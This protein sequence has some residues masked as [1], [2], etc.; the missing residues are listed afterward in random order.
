MRALVPAVFLS[1]AACAQRATPAPRPAAGEDARLA[2][3]SP[4]V[5]AAIRERRLVRGMSPAA[6]RLAW[7]E[8]TATAP[9]A[10]AAAPGLAYDRWRYAGAAGAPARE[11]WFA[12]GKVVDV[13]GPPGSPAGPGSP[14]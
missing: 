3:F 11:V 12:D 7:G 9:S 1:L 14:R 13:T 4:E 10:S 2:P 8:P 5:R 6:V